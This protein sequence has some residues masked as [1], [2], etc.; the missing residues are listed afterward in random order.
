MIDQDHCDLIM[1]RVQKYESRLTW[2]GRA[3]DAVLGLFKIHHCPCCQK[4]ARWKTWDREELQIN[5]CVGCGFTVTFAKDGKIY[6]MTMG[7]YS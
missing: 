3:R 2:I 5:L 4:K 1:R 6:D 7:D